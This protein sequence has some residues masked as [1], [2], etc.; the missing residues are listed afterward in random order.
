MARSDIVVS[1]GC[2]IVYIISCSSLTCS[3]AV[4]IHAV[5]RFHLL[6][7][8]LLSSLVLSMLCLAVA[9]PNQINTA[10]TFI[11]G[12]AQGEGLNLPTPTP[13]SVAVAPTAIS[14]NNASK[15]KS[16]IS[17]NR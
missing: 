14:G 9:S 11:T 16:N 17:M 15:T 10:L 12:F 3:R 2:V 6:Y 7:R 4:R 8:C 5:H 13:D 1:S